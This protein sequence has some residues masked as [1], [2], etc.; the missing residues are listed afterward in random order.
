MA[1]VGFLSPLS[2][3]LFGPACG[4]ILDLTPRRT[5]LRFITSAQTGAIATAGK[6]AAQS[7]I[8]THAHPHNCCGLAAG[9]YIL[10]TPC[11]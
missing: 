6:P 3:A 1:I 9:M 2:V 4:R 7:C 8:G 10:L 5:A 11:L